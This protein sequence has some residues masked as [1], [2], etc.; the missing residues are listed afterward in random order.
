[1]A[2]AGAAPPSDALGRDTLVG[3]VVGGRYR[4]RRRVGEGG[5]AVVYRADDEPGGGACALKVLLPVLAS[6]ATAMA[7]LRREAE[8]GRLLR[9][10]NVCPILAIDQIPDGPPYVVMPFLVGE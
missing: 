3:S 7:R 1:A 4:V 10:P 8:L 5:M 6:D 2:P 9:H